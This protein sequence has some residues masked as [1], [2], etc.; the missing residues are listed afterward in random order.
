MKSNKLVVG[1]NN[2]SKFDTLM[3]LTYTFIIFFSDN[4]KGALF[5]L[6]CLLVN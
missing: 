4:Q 5:S 3:L 6:S 2:L 1:R